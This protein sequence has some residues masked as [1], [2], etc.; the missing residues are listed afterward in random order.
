MKF[1][2]VGDKSFETDFSFLVVVPGDTSALG[3]YRTRTVRIQNCGTP[4]SL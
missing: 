4:T 1:Y 2:N 3:T